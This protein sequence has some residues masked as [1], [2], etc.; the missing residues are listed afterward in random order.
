MASNL[1]YNLLGSVPRGRGPPPLPVPNTPPLPVA[2]GA[3]RGAARGDP[4]EAP[5]RDGRGSAT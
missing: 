4:R 5:G 1:F 3:A 2:R